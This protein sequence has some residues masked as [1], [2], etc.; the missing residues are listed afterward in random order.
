MALNKEEKA[1][2]VKEYAKADAANAFPPFD[3]VGKLPVI[4]E[5]LCRLQKHPTAF[6]KRAFEKP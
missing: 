4:G 2:I 1:S 3:I 6:R 5:Q